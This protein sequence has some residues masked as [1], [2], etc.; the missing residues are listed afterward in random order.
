MESSGA[1]MV[2]QVPMKQG[3]ENGPFSPCIS[4]SLE[5]SWPQRSGS[6]LGKDAS[7]QWGQFLR[8]EAATSPPVGE[9]G[10]M[11]A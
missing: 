6:V 7:F 9:A 10:E 8:R 5:E 3:K 4:W 2:P 11:S 1:R